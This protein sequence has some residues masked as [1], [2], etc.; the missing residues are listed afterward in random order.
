M[1]GE[2]LDQHPRPAHRTEGWQDAIAAF[3][4]YTLGRVLGMGALASLIAA[5]VYLCGPFLTWNTYCCLVFAQLATWIPLAL[6]PADRDSHDARW[7]HAIA[8]VPSG[9]LD[10]V[11]A[12]I[13][14]VMAAPSSPL[15]RLFVRE[16][17]TIVPVDVDDVTRIEAHGDYVLVH[18]AG[19]RHMMRTNLQELESGLGG[20][21]FRVH[22]SHLVNLDRVVRFEP[23]DATRLAVVL[24]DSARV[25]A[26]R[27]RSQE[28]RRLAR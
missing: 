26:S 15:T 18:A 19:R 8:R 13:Q 6:R 1:Y 20:R 5:V 7:L 24:S 10:S 12:R 27:A 25:I 22:R 17:D 16:R 23:H 2:I 14:T 28:L 9:E 11:D 3:S 4:T 21:F